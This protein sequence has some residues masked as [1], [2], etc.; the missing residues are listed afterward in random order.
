L[1]DRPAIQTGFQEDDMDEDPMLVVEDV[2]G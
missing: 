1:H 2:S